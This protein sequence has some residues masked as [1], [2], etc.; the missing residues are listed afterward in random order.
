M[1]RL[2]ALVMLCALA[3]S[4][5]C[6][7]AKIV[8]VS[9]VVKVNGQP[10]A[11]AIVTFQPFAAKGSQDAQ[12][13]GSSAKT[14]KDGRFTLIYDGEKPGALVGKHR[15]RI[16]TDLNAAM[17]DT[18]GDPNAKRVIVRVNGRR[19]EPLPIEWHDQ[20]E[21]T[22]DVPS[23]GTTEANFDIDAPD[24]LPAKAKGKK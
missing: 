10:Y 22:F 21:K 20:S 16:C 23:G 11:N 14:D 7:G 8:P 6:G 15:V 18:E 9:G 2:F 24:L 5:G 4:T 3:S 17:E 1:K 19:V 12:G 13:R